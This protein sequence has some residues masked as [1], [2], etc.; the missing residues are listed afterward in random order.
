MDTEGA[1]PTATGWTLREF[2]AVDYDTRV[3]FH[4]PDS[5][6]ETFTAFLRWLRALGPSDGPSR[7]VFV[8]DNPAY[9]WPPIHW[10]MHRYFGENPFGHSA[11]R[12]GDFYAGLVG[13]FGRSSEWKSLRVT[14]H[15]HTPVNDALGNVEAFARMLAG[16]RGRRRHR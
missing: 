9:D 11:R 10:F 7:L 8:A 15:D 3:T 16:E 4:G 6:L 1:N 5:S 13:D 2:G 14:P 12:I